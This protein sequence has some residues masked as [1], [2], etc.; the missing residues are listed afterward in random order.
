MD[1]KFKLQNAEKIYLQ[2]FF[3]VRTCLGKEK[4]IYIHFGFSYLTFPGR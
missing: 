3:L 1:V 2:D 4:T